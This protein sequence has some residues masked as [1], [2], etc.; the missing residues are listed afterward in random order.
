MKRM[1]LSTNLE[2]FLTPLIVPSCH[3]VLLLLSITMTLNNYFFNY[4]EI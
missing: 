1:D 2:S 4:E 3:P